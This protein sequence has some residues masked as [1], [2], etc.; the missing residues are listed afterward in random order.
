[1]ARRTANAVH[2]IGCTCRACT[3]R[4]CRTG[5]T[6]LAIRGATRALLLIAA[7]I[8]IPFIIAHALAAAKGDNR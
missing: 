1:M 5:R 4:Q 7:V 8:A 3:P 2:P 6:D